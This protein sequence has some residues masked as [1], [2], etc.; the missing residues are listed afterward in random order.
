MRHAAR[1]RRGELTVRSRTD[2]A[3]GAPLRRCRAWIASLGICCLLAAGG[4]AKPPAVAAPPTVSLAQASPDLVALVEELLAS[5]RTLPTSAEMRGRL[6]MAYEVNDF[7]NA[8][9]EAYRQAEALDPSDFRW[10]YFRAMLVAELGDTQAALQAMAAALAIDDSY[11]PAWLYRGVWLASLGEPEAARTAFERAR[12]LGGESNGVAGIA[13][14][15]LAQGRAD[16]AAALLEPLS[17][18]LRHPHVYRLLGRTYQALGREDDARIALARGREPTPLQWRD[19]LQEQKWPL[20]ASYGGRL[21]HAENLLRVGRFDE[22]AEVLEPM[23]GSGPGDETVLANLSLAYGRSGRM[24]LAFETLREGFREKPDHF[25]FHNVMASLYQEEGEPASA[26]RHLRQSIERQPSQTW[27]YARLGLL[28]MEEGE[29]D[30]ALAALDRALELG[31]DRP[32]Q[33]LYTTALLEGI[34][35]RWA[36]AIDRLQRAVGL[37]PAF[38]KAYISLGRCLAEAGRY[39][40]AGAALAWAER[41]ATHPEELASARKR[42]ANLQAGDA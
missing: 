38:T 34:A 7:E 26:I 24:D 19:P 39:D 33:V 1:R 28:L 36:P 41:L 12:A 6:G 10:P 5:A 15:L 8:A 17:E 3:S 32:E 18:R 25:R 42:L 9:V 37:N 30:E 16:E 2:V 21:V 22:A 40:E 11:V 23:R 35:E 4:C 13:Q 20:L 27:P 31:I 29:Y 14:A